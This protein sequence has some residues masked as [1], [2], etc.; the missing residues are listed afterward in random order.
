MAWRGAR[1]KQLVSGRVGIKTQDF[2]I[3]KLMLLITRL[4]LPL[5]TLSLYFV[6]IAVYFVLEYC[7]KQISIN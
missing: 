1:V 6:F 4:N 5:L 3:R 2:Q 7:D